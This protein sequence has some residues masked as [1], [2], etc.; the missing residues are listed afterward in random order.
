MIDSLGEVGAALVDARPAGLA[1]LYGKL[2]MELRSEPEELAVY[3][4][5][6]P[7]VDNVC[8][9]GKTRTR[10]RSIRAQDACSRDRP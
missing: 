3:A 10:V 9:R 1:R 4:T 2:N 8:V 5:T 6:S 7:G